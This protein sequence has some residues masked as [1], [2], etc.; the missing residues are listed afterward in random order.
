MNKNLVFL[1]IVSLMTCCI[2]ID[3]SVP[4]FPDISDYFNISDGLTQMTIAVNFLGF[5]ISSLIYGPLSDSYGRRKIMIIGNII[6]LIGAC[7]CVFA[8]SIEQLLFSR[9]I[10]GFGASASAVVV[11]SIIAD[12]YTGTESIKLLGTINCL[13]TIFTSI[14]PIAGGIINES[15]GWRGSYTTIALVSIISWVLLYFNLPETKKDFEPFNI[16]KIIKNY[17]ML[18]TD[19]SFLYASVVP[20]LCYA[21]YMSFISYGSFLYMGTYNLSVMYYTLHQGIIVAMFSICSKYVGTI[22]N[23]LGQK[24]CVILGIGFLLLGGI[25]L[26]I[27][28]LFI[29]TSAYLTTF[30]MILFL[31]GGAISYPIIFSRAIEIF[32]EIRGTASSAIMGIRCFMCV[33]FVAFTSYIYNGTLLRLALVVLV[34]AIITVICTPKL[35]KLVGLSRC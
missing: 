33:I 23:W 29:K 21:A 15:I 8:S 9:F 20:N 17:K 25:N 26:V 7:G 28:A 19:Q 24:K 18:L 11:F 34:S 1:L 27:V 13:I 10:Q 6:M 3:V 32:P 31:I 22:S 14:A 12:V 35:L 4:S 16:Y 2:E 30:S 5:C